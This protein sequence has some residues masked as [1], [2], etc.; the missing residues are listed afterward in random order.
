[1][2]I[3]QISKRKQNEHDDNRDNKDR[4]YNLRLVQTP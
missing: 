2:L 3:S 1:M 4:Q